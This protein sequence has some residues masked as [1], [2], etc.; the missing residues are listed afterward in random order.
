MSADTGRQT[1]RGLSGLGVPGRQSPAE[2]GSTPVTERFYE[3]GEGRRGLASAWVAEVASRETGAAA[4]D[5]PQQ[6]PCTD[7]R[8]RRVL[9]PITPGRILQVPP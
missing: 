7:M 4:F 1:A 6:A 5:Y 3:Q 8:L 2:A 9:R